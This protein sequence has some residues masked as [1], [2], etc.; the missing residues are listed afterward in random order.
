LTDEAEA[1]GKVTIGSEFG[2]GASTDRLG[3]RH[4][5]EG[6]KNVL[7]HYG[8]LRWRDR[9][10]PPARLGARA[11]DQGRQAR[12]LCSVAAKRVWEPVV[13][14]GEAVDKGALLGRLHDFSD[15]SSPATDISGAG[16]RD[17]WRCCTWAPA[18]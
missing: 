7:R 2:R 18:P 13:Q 12:R 3:V 8:L 5:Y 9:Q 1:E 11:I 15:H 17:G 14:P 4:A 16:A 10:D 6:T